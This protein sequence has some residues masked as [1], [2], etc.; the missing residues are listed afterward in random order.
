MLLVL[1]A[2]GLSAR[3]VRMTA[4]GADHQ[5]HADSTRISRALASGPLKSYLKSCLEEVG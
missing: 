3:L 1:A 5:P 4:Y 2:L